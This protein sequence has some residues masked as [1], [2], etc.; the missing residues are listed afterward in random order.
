MNIVELTLEH[1]DILYN[2]LRSVDTKISEYSFSNLYLFRERHKYKLLENNNNYILGRTFD[3]IEYIMP[4]FDLTITGAEE[5]CTLAKE[6]KKIIF[7]VDE[8]WLELFKNFD[9]KVWCEEADRDY[10][11][12]LEK[13]CTYKGRKLHKKRNLLK[14]FIQNYSHTA[15]PLIKEEVDNAKIILDEWIN[16]SGMDIIETDYYPCLEAL[17]LLDTLV[18]CGII[19]Y[20][21]NK[22]AGFILGEE[23]HADTFAIHFAKANKKYK[24]IYQFMYN[25]FAKILPKNIHI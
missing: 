16:D 17:N 25:N 11:Y 18:L 24:G 7:P 1:K 21:D 23:I 3:N 15:K 2:D 4:A 22:P 10:I 6:L 8:R 5:I 9:I 13:M 20:V 12:T 14:Q 19:Y